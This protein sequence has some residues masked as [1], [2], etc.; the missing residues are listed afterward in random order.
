MVPWSK[1]KPLAFDVTCSDFFAPSRVH[2]PDGAALIAKEQQK[3][4]KYSELFL[5]HH[6]QAIAVDSLGRWGP[7]SLAFLQE[8]SRRL[9]A[10][11]CDPR[12]G[13]FLFQRLSIAVCQ[14]NRQSVCGTLPGTFPRFDF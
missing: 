12:A 3:E 6:V 13:N 11:T 8:L 14:G 5:T 7:S 2:L 10:R 4:A 9:R 1:G